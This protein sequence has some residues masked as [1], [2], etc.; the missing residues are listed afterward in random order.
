M[1]FSLKAGC[2]QTASLADLNDTNSLLSDHSC[3]MRDAWFTHT[4]WEDNE[5]IGKNDFEGVALKIGS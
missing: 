2:R 5:D 4:K 1:P 3:N